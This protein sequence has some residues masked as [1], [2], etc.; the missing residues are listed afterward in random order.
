MFHF[1]RNLCHIPVLYVVFAAI[2]VIIF[3]HFLGGS[4]WQ[5]ETAEHPGGQDSTFLKAGLL[6][7]RLSVAKMGQKKMIEKI[8]CF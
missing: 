2:S 3:C 4:V 8:L 6:E 7:G 1:C 5:T